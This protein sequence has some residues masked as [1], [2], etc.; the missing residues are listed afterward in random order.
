V[1]NSTKTLSCPICSASSILIHRSLPG[2]IAG[3]SYDVYECQDCNA[4]FANPLNSE[5]TVYESIYKNVSN[6]PG[7]QR[8]FEYSELVLKSKNPL[9]MLAN[10][11]NVYWAIREVLK[12]YN[13]QRDKIRILEI[14]CGLGYLTY[15]LNQCGF[16]CNGLDISEEAIINARSKYGNYYLSGNLFDM[17]HSSLEL[18]NSYD[19]VIMTELIEHVENPVEFV[20]AAM[21]LLNKDGILVVSTPNKSFYSG[22]RVW[23]SDVPPVHLWWMGEETIKKIAEIINANVK[24]VNFSGYLPVVDRQGRTLEDYSKQYPILNSD[25]TLRSL[26]KGSNTSLMVHRLIVA[27]RNLKSFVKASFSEGISLIRLNKARSSVLCAVFSKA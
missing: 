20:S 12:D 5:K 14:G 13:A 26:S 16:N 6:I 7:Y 3:K 1:S 2:Y 24:F 18:E 4:S 25:A 9:S 21:N 8:Y 15:S 17:A 22:N 27:A 23:Q 11:E 19:V 10:S